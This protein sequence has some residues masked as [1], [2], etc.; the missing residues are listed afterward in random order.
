MSLSICSIV[1]LNYGK[2][3]RSI[4]VN[5]C[6]AVRNKPQALKHSGI[7]T[8]NNT[9]GAST[10]NVLFGVDFWWISCSVLE[11]RSCF[12]STGGYH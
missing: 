3:N 9:F 1:C 7:K 11:V 6:I 2:G 10:F 12:A 5:L 8:L 4:A